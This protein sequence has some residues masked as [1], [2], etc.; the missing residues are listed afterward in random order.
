MYT[1]FKQK[2]G[3]DRGEGESGEGRRGRGS[4]K[5]EGGKGEI[6]TFTHDMVCTF[7]R[8]SVVGAT[9]NALADID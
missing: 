1:C 6:G 9:V 5:S 7:E 3:V 8:R 4:G 2:L